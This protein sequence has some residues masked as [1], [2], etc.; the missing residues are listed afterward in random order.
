MV[1]VIGFYGSDGSGV[2]DVG[3]GGGG[4]ERL[5]LFDRQLNSCLRKERKSHREK[6]TTRKSTHPLLQSQ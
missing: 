5:A 3:G 1:V 4:G 2:C 6:N